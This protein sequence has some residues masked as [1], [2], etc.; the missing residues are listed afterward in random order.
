MK[1]LNIRK[2]L[3]DSRDMLEILEFIADSAEENPAVRDMFPWRGIRAT[4]SQVKRQISS[5]T[6]SLG[7]LGGD[8][9]VQGTASTIAPVKQPLTVGDARPE[10]LYEEVGVKPVSP[11]AGRIKRIPQQVSRVREIEIGQL[12]PELEREWEELDSSNSDKSVQQT[13]VRRRIGE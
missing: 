11:L 12:A 13:N 7:S 4:V 9:L 3:V 8:E 6:E 1:S 10:S 5:V 2:T